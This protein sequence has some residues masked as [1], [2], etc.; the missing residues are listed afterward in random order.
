MNKEIGFLY[1]GNSLGKE[2]KMFL[3]IAKK[4]KIN[5]VMINVY[6]DTDENVLKEKIKNCGVIYNN[7]AED[8]GIEIAKTIEALGKKV[9]DSPK[10]YYFDE[11]KWM[12]F[13]KCKE[14]N[15]PSPETIL[16]SENIQIAKKELKNFGK[17]SVVLKRIEG[18][19]GQ[20]VDRAENINQAEKVI[21]KFWEK[22]DEKLPIIAQE[23]ISS[24][25]YRITVIG[26]KIVQTA[27]KKNKRGWKATGVY[28][29]KFEKFKIDRELKKIVNRVIKI[30]KIK[31]CGIDLL[32]K[33]NKWLVL[34]INSEP[35]LDFFED[36][37]E[38]L[39]EKVLVFLKNY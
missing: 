11:D 12:F 24:P 19:M 18:T 26:D 15:I 1:S 39:L 13:L 2:E 6:K 16:L 8:F 5:L 7:T 4:K 21:E 37:R 36:E 17:W 32:K 33:E 3:D 38:K 34:E 9:V 25:S 14:N 30:S 23:F 27:I 35:G 20:Y 22:G 31:I 28:G 29:K 10:A